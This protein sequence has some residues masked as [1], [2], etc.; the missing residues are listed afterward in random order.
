VAHINWRLPKPHFRPSSMIGRPTA[1][2]L[3]RIFVAAGKLNRGLSV[4]DTY[5][6]LI[7]GRTATEQ[8]VEDCE[9]VGWCIELVSDGKAG[10]V[11]MGGHLPF[12]PP[13]HTHLTR[14]QTPMCV[15]VF[16]HVCGCECTRN[17]VHWFF[18][19]P[20]HLC[21]DSCPCACVCVCMCLHVYVY[22][23]VFDCA[24]ACVCVYTRAPRSSRNTFW[25]RT[26]SW[27]IR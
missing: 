21:A 6:H 4:L 1:T 2:D 13:S 11:N 14:F 27:M 18:Y 5:R 25:W 24:R 22:V 23:C 12:A 26:T 15:C 8:E 17:C 3:L 10:W 19:L 7:G 9:V 20:T 16:P